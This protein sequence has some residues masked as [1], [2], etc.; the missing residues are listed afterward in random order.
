VL[1]ACDNRDIQR[2]RWRCWASRSCEPKCSRRA[3]NAS[4]KVYPGAD[5]NCAAGEL[6]LFDPPDVVPVRMVFRKAT[7]DCLSVTSLIETR[8]AQSIISKPFAQMPR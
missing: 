1:F 7:R 5:L 6:Q 3:V 8:E 2:H 4:A